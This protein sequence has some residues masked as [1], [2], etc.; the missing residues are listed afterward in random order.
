MLSKTSDERSTF[1]CGV[2]KGSQCDLSN[3][4]GADALYSASVKP[5][6]NLFPAGKAAFPTTRPWTFKKVLNL[7]K[8]EE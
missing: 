4:S 6:I 1:T 2:A 8:T 3:V 7:S 5:T